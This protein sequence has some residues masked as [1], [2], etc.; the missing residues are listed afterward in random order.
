M[1]P[2]ATGMRSPAGLGMVDGD[3]FYADNQ[4][5]YIGSGGIWHV[6]EGDFTGHPAGLRWTDEP[7]SP[8][9]ITMD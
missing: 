8:V 7:N 1:T 5:D 3:L 4:G 9:D 2:W 6:E